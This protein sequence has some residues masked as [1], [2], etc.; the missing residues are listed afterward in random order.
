MVFDGGVEPCRAARWVE[1]GESLGVGPFG[2]CTAPA[3]GCL[4]GVGPPQV[5]GIEVACEEGGDGFIEVVC[6]EV[7]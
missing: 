3:R 4:V 5:V 1:A 2:K 6:Q 7:V